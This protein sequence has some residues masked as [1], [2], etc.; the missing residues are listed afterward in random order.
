MLS[1][2]CGIRI[3]LQWSLSHRNGGVSRVDIDRS[4]TCLPAAGTLALKCTWFKISDELTLVEW[5]H[6]IKCVPWKFAISYVNF[7][8][9][10][11]L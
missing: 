1:P 2:Y 7:K 8:F 10:Q 9:V 11:E 3:E 4:P 6:C 5:Y